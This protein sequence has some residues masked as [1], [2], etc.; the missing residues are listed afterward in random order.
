MAPN[1]AMPWFTFY[2]E[3][4]AAVGGALLLALAAGPARQRIPVRLPALVLMLLVGVVL[5]QR[6]VGLIPFNG[7]ALLAS[8]YLGGFAVLY[9]LAGASLPRDGDWLLGAMVAALTVAT[10]VSAGLA[11][12]QWFGLTWLNMWALEAPRGL[13]V[14]ANLLQPNHLA[15]LLGCG[16]AALA[17]L[18]GTRRIG[19][20]GA[21]VAAGF[22]LLAMAMTQS[23]TPWLMAAVLGL[24]LMARRRSVS[25]GRAGWLAGVALLVW[26]VLALWATFVLPPALLLVDP[27][28]IENSRLS[29]GARPTLWRQWIVA[30]GLQPWTGWGWLQGF[31]AQGA[32]ATSAPGESYSAYAH[33][34]VLDLLAWNGVPL[35]LLLLGGLTWWYLRAG[36]AATG[37]AQ[38]FRFAAI[39]CI[40]A[41]AMVEYP[42]AYA[43]FVVPL[44]LLA[45]QFDAAAGPFVAGRSGVRLPR[46]TLLAAG[47]ACIAGV[48]AIVH[49]Y[50]AIEE[51]TRLLRTQFAKIG[52]P[53]PSEPPR[54]IWVLD[55][56]LALSRAARVEPR[57]GMDAAQIAALQ[58]IARRFPSAFMLERTA[59]ALA[60]NG[61]LDAA[62]QALHRLA[63]IHGRPAGLAA[64]EHVETLLRESHPTL[65]PWVAEVRASLPAVR[66]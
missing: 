31:A 54:D 1:W 47:L 53:Q 14:A 37:P 10:L 41:H 18:Y 21:V 59:L 9:T 24:W 49:D 25:L 55:H 48:L 64:V 28:A 19:G 22:V 12:Y 17:W 15:T 52:R 65:L 40:G 5:V 62:T 39:T 13:R 30:I 58:R 56:M 57:P 11:I 33:S 8:L 60:L 36:L 63:G 43:Y 45:G 51:D 34:I 20:V 27:A 16:L 7:D 4:C 6:A 38:W 26:Y 35:G 2:V 32:A 66:R 29:A 61:D 50:P 42:H 44:A 46:W 23:R 3:M